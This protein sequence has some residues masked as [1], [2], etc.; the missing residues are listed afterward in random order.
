[1]NGHLVTPAQV[2]QSYNRAC[3][4]ARFPFPPGRP[5][6]RGIEDRGEAGS[7]DA[8]DGS[9]LEGS[10]Y[11]CTIAVRNEPTTTRAFLADVAPGPLP[12]LRL[13]DFST[14]AAGPP[15]FWHD[16]EAV[17]TSKAMGYGAVGAVASGT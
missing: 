3:G 9:S 6:V 10:P 4:R 1:M 8:V 16:H 12:R 7:L 13:S 14:R 2:R 5:A 11:I 15:C 17:Q